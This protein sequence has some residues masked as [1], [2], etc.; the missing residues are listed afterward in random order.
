MADSTT[1]SRVLIVDDEPNILVVLEFL[2]NKEGYQVLKAANG[3]EA[4]EIIEKEQPAIVVLDVMMPEMDGFEVAK[5]IRENP[6]YQ[7]IRI[8]FLTAKGT[9][10]D[11]FKGYDYGGEVY[12]TKPFDNDD[13]V[14]TVNE[15][16]EYGI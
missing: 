10:A 3:I 2:L 12:L 8:I 4:L 1:K 14:T 6:N 11:R 13:F 15:V 9:D 7:N 16:M 5:K